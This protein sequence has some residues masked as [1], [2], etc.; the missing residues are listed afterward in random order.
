MKILG[1]SG[2]PIKNSKMDRLNQEMKEEI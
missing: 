1:I 2:S